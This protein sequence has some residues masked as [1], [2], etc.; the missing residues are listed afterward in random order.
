MKKPAFILLLGFLL[1][2]LFLGCRGEE[3][4]PAWET[5]QSIRWSDNLSNQQISGF[6]EDAFGYIWI[7]TQNG[8]NKYNGYQ[9]KQHFHTNDSTSL[10]HN[11]ISNVFSDSKGQLWV[12]T[13]FGINRSTDQGGFQRIPI[14]SSSQNVAQIIETGDGR[15]FINTINDICEYDKTEQ[16]FVKRIDLTDGKFALSGF[17]IDKRNCLWC[18]G[19]SEVSCYDGSDF[20]LL[21]SYPVEG[22]IHKSHLRSN[23]EL[24]LGVG[25]QL[26]IMDLKSGNL[27]PTPDA[28]RN[29]PVLS[30]AMISLIHPYNEV[31]L[32]IYT[33]KDGLFLVN[34]YTQEVIHQAESSFPFQV[35]EVEITSFFTDSNKNLWIGSY[36]QGFKV[37]YRDT[38]LFNSND[39]LRAQTENKS[40]I[41]VTTDKEGNLWIA[42]RL[43]GLLLCDKDNNIQ[44]VDITPFFPDFLYYKDRISGVYAD[45][46]NNIWL[47]TNNR[48]I[49]CKY[50]DKKLIE[51]KTFW[52]HTGTINAMVE[53]HQGTLW[54]AGGSAVLYYWEEKRDEFIPIQLYP[55]GFNF[56]NGLFALSNGKLIIASFQKDLLFFDPLTHTTEEIAVAPLINRPSFVPTCIYEDGMGYVWM[57]SFGNGLF[58]YNLHTG[59]M[60]KMEGIDSNEVISIT[61]DVQGSLWFGTLFGLFKYDRTVDRFTGYYASDGIGG[62]QFNER[63]VTILPNNS[64]V[65]GGTHGLTVFDPIN[66]SIRRQI[67]LY[68]EE[69]FIHNKRV[70]PG[71]DGKIDKAMILNPEV[72]LPYH[73]NNLQ[74]AYAALDY[75]DY[76]NV[77]YAYRLEGFDDRWV[78]ARNIR[79]AFYSNLPAGN[80]TFQ[81]KASNHDNTVTEVIASLP[82]HIARAPWLTI[83]ALCLYLLVVMGLIW[84]FFRMYLHILKSRQRAQQALQEKEHEQ[85]LNRMNMSFF[86]NI[87]HEFRTPLT[88]ISGPITTLCQD[89]TIQ[90]GNKRLLFIVQRSVRRMLRL[91]NQILD[92]NKL[93]NDALRLKVQRMDSVELINRFVDIFRP[94]FSERG[95][96]LRMYGL[97]DSYF[98]LIDADKLEKIL[99][100][101]ISNAMKFSPH[102]VDVKVSYDI[103][104][105]EE[106]RALC[107]KALNA[108]ESN[109]IKIVVADTGQGI[110][111]DRLEAIFQRYYQIERQE[112]RHQTWGTGIGL[113]FARRLAEM[114]H[115]CLFAE[116]QKEGTG[117]VFTLLLPVNE[118]IYTEEEKRQEQQAEQQ[119]IIPEAEKAVMDT[120]STTP[121]NEENRATLLVVDDD[122]EIVRY[123]RELLSHSYQVESCYDGESAWKA[124][125]DSSPD[126][127]VSDVIMPGTDGYE[128]CRRIKGNLSTSHIPVIL[129]TAK[130]DMNDQVE[131]LNV[132]ANAYVTKPFDPVY[133]LALI[134]SQLR[135]RDNVR[136]Q[137][138]DVTAA[139]AISDELLT[140]QD[141]AFMDNLYLLMEKEL[142]NPEL[143]ITRMT[144]VL[145]IS[146]TKFY[147]K[148]KGLTGENPNIFFKT[149]K[150][151]RAAELIGEGKYT[152]SEIADMTGFSTHSHF[153]SSF[154]KRFGVSPSEYHP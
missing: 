75:S 48:Q 79:Q 68:I 58:R 117:A 126:L 125:E 88:M 31:S 18:V 145:H 129:V 14:E 86:A 152:M 56:T 49:R 94:N 144:E 122:T 148:V 113:Y 9:F 91:V 71:R 92:F 130:V 7:A 43:H 26:L 149:Y 28:Y 89:D 97:D 132:G 95:L 142:S 66:I 77:Q 110:P 83:P 16:R 6:G 153:S 76:P 57:G 84:L 46:K 118:E 54:G 81:V 29:H 64:V 70:Q 55:P 128:L 105:E 65:F 69:L 123:L 141:K 102:G 22:M 38:K 143:N 112:A 72:K 8:L 121:T 25:N 30:K 21:A 34:T 106:A 11:W 45:K 114:H 39:F 3:Q 115:G 104:P 19:F 53:D 12:T 139:A 13:I 35:P 135:N 111:P 67:P 87:S 51:E 37:I 42:T 61:E 98:S 151:N 103:I 134:K 17:Y 27:I 73:E 74:F 15:L 4:L 52:L 60:E 2:L 44:S 59:E 5:N 32:L 41:S 120:I 124:I 136:Q 82:V 107:G 147:Y 119:Y 146:R 62:N 90:E 23:G 20:S 133:L 150:L 78:E 108:I 85:Y 10:S 96:T 138:S 127:I 24:W 154:K 93:E 137:L 99:V 47:R 131:G 100:N 109:Y 40:V 140:A 33:Q 1:P 36:D 101:L 63:C 50:R 80:Y 116:N